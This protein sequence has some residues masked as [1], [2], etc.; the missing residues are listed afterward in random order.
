[1]IFFSAS[2]FGFFSSELH[3][4]DI[5]QDAVE[6][7]AD[8]F[9]ALF[10]GQAAGAT[11]IAGADGR[12]ELSWPPAPDLQA[13]RADAAAAVKREAA[14]RITAIAPP[15]RQDNDNAAIAQAA[16]ETAIGA[17]AVTVD[18]APALARRSAIDAVRRTSDEIEAWI[19]TMPAEELVAIDWSADEHWQ[20]DEE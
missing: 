10:D 11:I 20:E 5:P 17:A 6:I 3:G 15:W 16:L 2:A 1:M 8:E 4:G 13:L 7:S 12:P 19:A 9:S 14:R 18:F